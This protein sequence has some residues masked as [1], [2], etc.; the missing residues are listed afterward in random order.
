[1]LGTESHIMDI[2]LKLKHSAI[3]TTT[4]FRI[5][6]MKLENL[7]FW[8]SEFYN[9]PWLFLVWLREIFLLKMYLFLKFFC[10]F[11]WSFQKSKTSKMLW[12][13]TAYRGETAYSVNV[14]NQLVDFLQ[15]QKWN[16]FNFVPQSSFKRTFFWKP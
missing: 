9:K 2:F 14:K 8:L 13:I 7:S 3:I 11:L 1:M 10:G 16:R 12:C 15:Q 6:E 5:R 4:L